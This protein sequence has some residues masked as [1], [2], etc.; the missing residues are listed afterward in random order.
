MG[1]GHGCGDLRGSGHWE[2]K[3]D[4][5]PTFHQ[6][7]SGLDVP[8]DLAVDGARYAVLKLQVHLGDG[9]LGEDGGVGDITCT[10]S[11]LHSQIRCLWS[12]DG[13]RGER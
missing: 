9:V 12:V 3:L 5:V 13:A 6:G 2:T 10:Q 1:E 7:S 8:H 11:V 4:I